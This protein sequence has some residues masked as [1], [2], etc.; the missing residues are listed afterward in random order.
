MEAEVGPTTNGNFLLRRYILNL[1]GLLEGQYENSVW[2]LKV[3]RRLFRE[4]KQE[5]DSNRLL[6]K[7][8]SDTKQSADLQNGRHG[9]E[10]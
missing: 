5:D 6:Y 1:Y 4:R 10:T 9:V 2:Q 8:S 7:T 3:C